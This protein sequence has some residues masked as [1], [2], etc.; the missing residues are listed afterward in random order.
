MRPDPRSRHRLT[1]GERYGPWLV[2]FSILVMVIFLGYR[3]YPALTQS[4]QDSELMGDASETESSQ[5]SSEETPESTEPK[6]PVP[7]PEP[8]PEPDSELDAESESDEAA[9]DELSEDELAE[10]ETEVPAAEQREALPPLDESDAELQEA[11]SEE[12]DVAQ[13]EDWFVPES[14]IRHFVVTIDNL[15]RAELPQKYSFV[16]S[17][18]KLFKVE[19]IDDDTY[20]IDPANYE[21]YSRYIRFVESIELDNFTSVY[22][23]F[24]PLFQ[25][26]YE[27][28][29]YPDRYFNDR[30]IQVIDHLLEMPE[31]D[32][33][34][35]L[36][37][38]KVYYKYAD[39]KLESFSAGRK[40]LLRIGPENA[41]KVKSKLLELRTVLT[42]LNSESIN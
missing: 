36:V 33:P 7:V 27:E 12:R 23:R 3:Y 20:I 5:E 41:N 2:V 16:E 37:R 39:K 40:I 14:M 26:A 22:V 42:S 21:R 32:R 6:Y 38:P 8:M 18:P 10:D 17:A 35:E 19:S 11:L 15:T 31:V 1:A 34:I 30:L 4:Y 25:Q 29:G 9:S 28:L 13:L 24:Y